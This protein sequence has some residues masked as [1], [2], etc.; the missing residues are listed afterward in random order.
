M[1]GKHISVTHIAGSSTKTMLNGGQTGMATGAAAFLCKKRQ[2]LPRDVG[3]NHITELQEI[4]M[5]Q[6]PYKDSL[7]SLPANK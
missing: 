5:E 1:A 6:G 2:V 4:L 3:Q 7:Q